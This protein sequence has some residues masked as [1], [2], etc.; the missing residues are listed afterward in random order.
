MPSLTA[1]EK[2]K[3]IEES[4]ILLIG[5]VDRPVPS[6]LHL[7]KEFFILHLV[8]PNFK[9]IIRFRKHYFGPYSSDLR[10]AIQNPIEYEGAFTFE[11]GKVRI[12]RNFTKTMETNICLTSQGKEYYKKLVNL[13][14]T[15]P[16]GS[17]LLGIL[18][19]IRELYDRLSPEE[20]LLLIYLTHRD[21]TE[22]SEIASKI[23]DF[24]ERRRI[25]TKLY[26]KGLISKD[27]CKEI[28]Q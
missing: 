10:E 24:K 22:T 17:T 11:I 7:E 14:K 25:A 3:L 15:D 13:I 27:R 9:K 8:V 16:K 23:L 26:E 28:V 12:F 4:L 2:E 19:S 21:Y 18:K 20:L 5:V 1:E 6:M